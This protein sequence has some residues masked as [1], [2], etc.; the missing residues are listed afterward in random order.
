M[1]GPLQYTNIST[2]T[3]T[4]AQSQAGSDAKAISHCAHEPAHLFV[5]LHMYTLWDKVYH[6]F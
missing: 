3:V 5:Y 6:K 1:N 4:T 2:Q